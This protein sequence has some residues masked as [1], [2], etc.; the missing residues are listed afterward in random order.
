VDAADRDR[1]SVPAGL[2][3]GARTAPEIALSI[4]AEL[5]SLRR[6]P[7]VDVAEGVAATGDTPEPGTAVDPVCGM[8]VLISDTTISAEVDGRTHWFCCAG[9]RDTYLADRAS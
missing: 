1:V 3:I 9:C 5:I 2:D 4:L 7:T 6:E 8:T